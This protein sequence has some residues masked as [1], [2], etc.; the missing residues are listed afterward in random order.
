MSLLQ[1][2]AVSAQERYLTGDTPT[3]AFFRAVYRR[4]YHSTK[5]YSLSV[6][7]LSQKLDKNANISL[8]SEV[9]RDLEDHRN[10]RASSRAAAESA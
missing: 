4:K 7:K 5:L 9:W 8:P 6:A 1:F 10:R 2:L 3:I